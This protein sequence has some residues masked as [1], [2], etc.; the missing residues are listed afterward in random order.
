[1]SLS[2]TGRK[3]KV[4]LKEELSHKK[5]YQDV[6]SDF[7]HIKIVLLNK[8][9]K[10]LLFKDDEINK[11]LERAINN[12]IKSKI[13]WIKEFWL[14]DFIDIK[15]S[16][17]KEVIKSKKLPKIAIS[18]NHI[19]VCYK[20]N[21]YHL[22][23]TDSEIKKALDRSDDGKLPS[24]SWLNIKENNDGK[25]TGKKQGKIKTTSIEGEKISN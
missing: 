23:F 18:M 25:I 3:V 20:N 14:S 10:R 17:F 9:E 19:R 13:S 7:N 16:D 1:M 2:T 21:D 12:N 15:M 6:I 8:T 24:V 4:F 22:L 5:N 11:A